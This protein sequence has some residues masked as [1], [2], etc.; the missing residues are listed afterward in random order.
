MAKEFL[1]KESC[2]VC[3]CTHAEATVSTMW[4]AQ[5]RRVG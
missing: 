5:D 2:A 1:L 4:A 3:H